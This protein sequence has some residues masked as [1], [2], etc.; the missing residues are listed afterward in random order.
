MNERNL[1]LK[2]GLRH[3]IKGEN[4]IIGESIEGGGDIGKIQELDIGE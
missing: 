2:N 3:H 1:S 4:F